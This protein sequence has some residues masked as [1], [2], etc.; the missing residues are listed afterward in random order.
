MWECVSAE[1]AR[2][3]LPSIAGAHEECECRDNRRA[4]PQ[5]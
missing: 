2:N 3:R 4:K 1:V 5:K